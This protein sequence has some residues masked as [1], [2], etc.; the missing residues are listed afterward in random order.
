MT[1]GFD[2][3]AFMPGH[4]SSQIWMCEM[5]EPILHGLFPQKEIVIWMVSGWYALTNFILRSRN[6]LTIRHFVSIDEDIENTSMA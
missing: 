4:I 6:E 1:P 3:T 5:L 2:R